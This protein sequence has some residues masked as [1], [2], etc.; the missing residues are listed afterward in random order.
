MRGKHISEE[1]PSGKRSMEEEWHIF[2]DVKGSQASLKQLT[3]QFI[4][5]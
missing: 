3:N 4:L 2:M 5:L 1:N